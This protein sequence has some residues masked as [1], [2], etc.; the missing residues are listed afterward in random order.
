MN[1]RLRRKAETRERILGAALDAF[2]EEGAG[3]TLSSVAERAGVAKAS[4]FF[5]FK[6]RT[7]LLAVLAVRLY[8]ESRL[9]VRRQG[10]PASAVDYVRAV[11]VSQRDPDAALLW[12]ISD[13]LVWEAPA[14]AERAF[15]DV[16]GELRRRLLREGTPAP[17][18]ASLAAVLGQAL[19]MMA[20]RVSAAGGRHQDVDDFVAGVRALLTPSG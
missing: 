10:E 18:A 19:L 5:H 11:L 15:A 12:R 7:D 9:R 20:R 1:V 6:T 2:R 16:E 14:T 4:V 13:A 3:T 17:R 8:R